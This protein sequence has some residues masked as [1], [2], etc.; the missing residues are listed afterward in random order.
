MNKIFSILKFEIE[1]FNVKILQH[2]SVWLFK[3]GKHKALIPT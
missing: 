3:I 2:L 1:A